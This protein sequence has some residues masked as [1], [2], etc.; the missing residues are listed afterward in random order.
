M[1]CEGRA[2]ERLSRA[3]APCKQGTTKMHTERFRLQTLI[4]LIMYDTDVAERQRKHAC[5]CYLVHAVAQAADAQVRAA[6][7]MVYLEADIGG[8]LQHVGVR[9]LLALP[10]QAGSAE[11]STIITLSKQALQMLPKFGSSLCARKNFRTVP[12]AAFVPSVLPSDCHISL[13]LHS[14]FTQFCF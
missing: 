6:Q 1:T 13:Q 11:S 2:C 3:G 9:C 7:L 10:P 5:R 14:I 12:V 8:V 4:F